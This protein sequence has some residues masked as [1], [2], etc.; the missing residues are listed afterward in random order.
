MQDDPVRDALFEL[1]EP[2]PDGIC[3]PS[4]APH[5]SHARNRLW[6]LNTAI[7]ALLVLGATNADSVER[8]AAAQPPNWGTETVRLT[9]GVFA[10]RM[11]LIGLDEPKREMRAQ[12]EDWKQ[13]DWGD[14][15]VE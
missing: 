4:K 1:P 5:Q 13:A 7:A 12:W 2:C 10:E 6:L 9:A 3:D 15:G 11:A 14:V 8:W